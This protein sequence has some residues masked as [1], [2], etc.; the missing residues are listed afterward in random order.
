M[1]LKYDLKESKAQEQRL[2]DSNTELEE[3]NV[4]L[5]QQVQKLRESLIDLDSLKLENK[6]LQEN[7]RRRNFV[8]FY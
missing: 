6:Q 5:Q 8:N 4:T 3:D 1:K 2:I 7:V